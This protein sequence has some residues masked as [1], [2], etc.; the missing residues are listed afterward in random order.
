MRD[1]RGFDG[2]DTR[3]GHLYAFLPLAAWPLSAFHRAW[4]WTRKYHRQL[5]LIQMDCS[6]LE[7]PPLF[8]GEDRQI[9]RLPDGNGYYVIF[10]SSDWELVEAFRAVPGSR[11]H[12]VPISEHGRLFYR[13]RT[14]HGRLDSLLRF[15]EE[16]RFQI[17]PHVRTLVRGSG[18]QNELG[19]ERK[20]M[21]GSR[22]VVYEPENNA[23]ELYFPD[24]ALNG[25]VKSIPCR[26]HSYTGGFHWIIA[27]KPPA[28]GPLRAFLTRHAFA[29][30]ADAEQRLQELERE[31][32]R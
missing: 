1:D 13:Y 18:K 28:A 21:P 19:A 2:S 6:L 16:Y 3:A 20:E 15:A 32:N 12:T 5:E 14:Y 22:H 8:E 17:G 30:P 9:A 7:E 29:L 25:E 23:F 26:S 11:L 27:A 4:S 24:L 31:G 10:P